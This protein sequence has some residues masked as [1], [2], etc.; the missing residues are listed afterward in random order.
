M[1]SKELGINF[2]GNE[3]NKKR[4]LKRVDILIKNINKITYEVLIKKLN[5]NFKDKNSV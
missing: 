2:F 4:K 1:Y 5:I 3:S